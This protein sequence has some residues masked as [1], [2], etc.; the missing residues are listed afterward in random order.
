MNIH[1]KPYVSLLLL[2]TLIPAC[3]ISV[4][5]AQTNTLTKSDS[6]KVELPDSVVTVAR[7]AFERNKCQT[8][9]SMH[10]SPTMTKADS[11]TKH[12]RDLSAAGLKRTE[13]WLLAFLQKKE[14]LDGKLHMKTFAGTDAEFSAV[15]RW[16]AS[17][18]ADTTL[19]KKPS[20]Q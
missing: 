11:T 7:A 6:A 9:H 2:S 8:C 18:K 14:K 16:L 4:T 13:V 19:H 3:A 10:F 17:Q 15:S 12:Q 5:L 1:N 20:A